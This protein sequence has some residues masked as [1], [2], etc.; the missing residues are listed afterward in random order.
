VIHSF[1]VPDFRIKQ[2]TVP[3]L[4]TTMWFKATEPGEHDALC[5]EYCGLAH[6]DMLTKVVVLP[7]GEF[8][9]WYQAVPAP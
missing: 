7:V 9:T 5:A 1:F 3:G 4:T 6:S 8:E 2:D